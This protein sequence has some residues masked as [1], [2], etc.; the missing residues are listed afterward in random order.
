[1]MESE[2]IAAASARHPRPDSTLAYQYGTAGFRTRW[3][4]TAQRIQ[5]EGTETNNER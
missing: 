1:M 5:H 4:M 3:A 2:F